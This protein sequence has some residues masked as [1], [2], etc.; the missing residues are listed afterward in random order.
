MKFTAVLLTVLTAVF[1]Q[2]VLARYAV[3]GTWAFDLVVVGVVFAALQWGPMAGIVAGTLG[4]LAQDLL[5]GQ[6]VG[7][8]GLSK[9]AV[10]FFAG[11][12]G[13]QFLLVKPA[14]RMGVAA[15]ASVLH[16]LAMLGLQALIDQQWPD[17]SWLS[18]TAETAINS[19]CALVL[20]QMTAALPGMVERQRTSRRSSLSRRQW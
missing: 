14:G 1:L 9:T 10:G 20:F 7:L 11:A 8:G 16:R 19:A 18:L 5:S 6:I 3:G 17:V 15:V 2:V 13:T 12:I 4:G